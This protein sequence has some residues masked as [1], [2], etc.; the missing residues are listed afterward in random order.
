MSRKRPDRDR[1]D[2]PDETDEYVPLD[3]TPP[4]LPAAPI[5]LVDD[6]T[7]GRSRVLKRR[8][9]RPA[10]SRTTSVLGDFRLLAR[11]GHGSM[12]TVYRARQ[13]SVGREVALK[14][15]SKEMAG[16]PGFV[17]RF[18]REA[19]L[20]TKLD[21]LHIVR[22]FAVGE[23][24]G[25]HYLAMEYAGGGSVQNWL[26]K[27]GRFAVGDALHIALACA[28]ALGYAHEQGM[29]HRDIKPDNLLLT[30]DGIVKL[31]DLGLA[32]ASDEDVDLTR[33]GIG[34]GTPLYAPPE[35]VRNAKQA[36][37]RSDLYALGSVLY[38]LLA[39]RPPFEG[40]NFLEVI[41]AKERG[42]FP[43]LR[44]LRTEVPEVVDRALLRLLARQPEQRYQSCDE[45]IEELAW[46][47]LEAPSLSFFAE[48]EQ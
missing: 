38:H 45:L 32:K 14:V 4:V 11:L 22:C 10:P 28:G 16:R 2:D 36:D 34:I 24:H 8:D 40:A 26:E 41:Q 43:L 46:H 39:G 19:R 42:K 29:V 3:P 12:G 37:A 33:T 18:Q 27:L 15:L 31:A 44:R 5:P 30:A 35:Q 6:P 13:R 20:M 48:G 9:E 21:H 7:A 17:Q 1:S 23:A 25:Y 47:R